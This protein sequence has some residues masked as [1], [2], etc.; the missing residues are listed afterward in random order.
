MARHD[1]NPEGL[2]DEYGTHLWRLDRDRLW[3]LNTAETV[4]DAMSDLKELKRL[5]KALD[6]LIKRKEGAK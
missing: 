1:P 2:F 3:I 4:G 5:R 6:K